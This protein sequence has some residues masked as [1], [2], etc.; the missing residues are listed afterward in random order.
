[1]T[2]RHSVGEVK[3]AINYVRMTFKEKRLSMRFIVGSH[4]YIF[5]I[6]ELDLQGKTGQRRNYPSPESWESAK[7]T[8]IAI[9]KG[10]NPTYMVS[11]K[12]R[13]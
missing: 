5:I 9:I 7:E 3:N 1:M 10:R 4:P 11:W 12:P 8:E 13:K 2:I 6:Y